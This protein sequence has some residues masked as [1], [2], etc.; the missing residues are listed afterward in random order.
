MNEFHIALTGHR[1]QKL[2]G[3]NLNQ[4]YYK[5][6]HAKLVDIIEQT[7]QSH[8]DTTIWVHSGMALGAD[9]VWGFAAKTAIANH[10]GLV[11]FHAEIPIMTQADKWFNQLDKD[12]WKI[13][14]DLADEK[15][16]YAEA[17]S[18]VVMQERNVGMIDHADALIA[19]WDGS[20]SGTAN[21]V[22]YARTKDMPTLYLKPN[23]FN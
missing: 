21:A 19:I 23:D 20:K 5:K 18:P 4:P 8:P 16:I 11:K 10:P 9:T 14:Y 1:P 7:I 2:A 17:Y 12:R 3:Y 22:K 15:T 13:L 6:M